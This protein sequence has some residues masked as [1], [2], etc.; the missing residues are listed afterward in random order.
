MLLGG[1]AAWPLAARAQQG[2]RMRRIGVLM[3]FADNDSD[4]QANIAAFRQAF[5][6]RGWTDS[7]NVHIDYRW[8]GADRQRI[9]ADAH[10]LVGLMPDVT[11]ASIHLVLHPLQLQ[12][13]KIRL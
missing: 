3:P 13:R 4:A 11:V 7:R 2:E 12:P 10:E 5:Q 8:V 1:A 6:M 9:R